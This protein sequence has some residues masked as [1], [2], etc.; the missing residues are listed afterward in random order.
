MPTQY[1]AN[2]EFIASKGF[3]TS[4]LEGHQKTLVWLHITYAD[5]LFYG[6]P[7]RDEFDIMVG[8]MRRPVLIESV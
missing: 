5:N 7:S 2:L 1:D 6:E 3:D 8:E 4:S